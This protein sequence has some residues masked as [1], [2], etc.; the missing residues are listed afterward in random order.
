MRAATFFVVGTRR[1][2]EFL[3]DAADRPL[4]ED[5]TWGVIKSRSKFCLYACR[6][7]TG[8]KRIVL[9]HRVIMQPEP[10]MVVDHIDGNTLNNRRYNLRILSVR[11]NHMRKHRPTI[12]RAEPELPRGVHRT[13][14]GKFMA[15][16]KVDQK[17][18]YLGTFVTVRDAA[19]AWNAAAVAARGDLAVLNTL[20]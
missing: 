20:S 3:I 10:G 11:E 9:L 19:A 8:L 18:Q 1:G 4:L 2:L 12:V 13:E 5:W 14:N 16:I 15:L 7:D 6:T 17:M